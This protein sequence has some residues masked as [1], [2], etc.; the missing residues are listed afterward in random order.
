MCQKIRQE[1]CGD[2]CPSRIKDLLLKAT[3][4]KKQNIKSL[5]ISPRRTILRLILAWVIIA[6]TLFWSAGTF[7]W[8]EAWIFVL[9]G[10]SFMLMMRFWMK[11]NSPE[12]LKKRM[13]TKMPVKNW[14]KITSAG[15]ATLFLV[16]FLTV[17]FDARYDWSKVPYVFEIVGFVGMI[18][19]MYYLVFASLKENPYLA[20]IVEMQEGQKVITTGPYKWVRQPFYLGVIIVYAL[21]PLALG[22]LYALI[23][24]LLMTVLF[25]IRASLEDK[26]LQNELRGYKDYTKKTPYI[27]LHRVW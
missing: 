9:L 7:Y 10:F 24:S 25:I 6:T 2:Y 14:D 19:S 1:L 3:K 18:I 23:P 13:L 26:M 27:L 17:G 8:L 12:L 22:S 4:M 16:L 5:E 20:K 15:F 11:K 21:I